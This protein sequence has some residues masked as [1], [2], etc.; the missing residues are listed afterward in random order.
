M[1]R[2]MT[3]DHRCFVGP[4]IGGDESRDA[5]DMVWGDFRPPCSSLRNRLDVGSSPEG[6]PKGADHQRR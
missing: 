1:V 5:Q 6:R 3:N 2:G 4:N